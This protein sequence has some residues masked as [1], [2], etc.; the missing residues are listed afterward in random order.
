MIT[1]Y[2]L[3]DKETTAIKETAISESNEPSGIYNLSGLY[4]GKST[5][6]LPAGIYIRN[7]KKIIIR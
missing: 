3:Q 1:F 2:Y 7:G 6:G 4:V 5:E